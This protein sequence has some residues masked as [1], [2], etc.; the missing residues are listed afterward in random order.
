MLLSRRNVMIGAAALG[1]GPALAAE[2]RPILV[3]GA[4]ARSA[5][6]ILR[7]GLAQG[8]VVTAL[9]RR[10]EA[11]S[12]KDPA[13][14]VMKGDAYDVDSLAAAMTGREVVISLIG[15]R[16]DPAMAGPRNADYEVGYVDIYS[17][18]TAAIISAMR[19]KG[20]TRLMVTSSGGVEIIPAEKPKTETFP[21]AWVW[22]ARNLYGDMQR[23]EKI[24]AVSDLDWIVLRP[25]TFRD[26]PARRDLK[27]AVGVPT[28]NPRSTLTYADFAAFVL[29][30][31]EADTYLRKAVGIYTDKE[32]RG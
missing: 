13:L 7:Q 28:P 8:R 1:A 30:Q 25:R 32:L 3:I 29:E 9:A 24:V 26:E 5:P 10:P 19:R 22:K 23:M 31:A 18:G 15:P 11:V 20:N 21:E 16:N 27:F 12:V 17:V 6:E 4:T 2:R 14:R